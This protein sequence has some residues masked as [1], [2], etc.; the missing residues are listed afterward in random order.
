MLLIIKAFEMHF[1]EMF[2]ALNVIRIF[3]GAGLIG[4]MIS[5]YFFPDILYGLPRVPESMM[6][7]K[8][9]KSSE[10]SLTGKENTNHNHFETS[11]LNSIGH[12]TDACMKE[13]KPYLQTDCNLASISKLMNIPVHHLTYY[14][15]QVKKQHFTEY[16]NEWRINHAKNLIIEGKIKLTTLENIGLQSGFTNRNTFLTAFKRLEGTSPHAYT[17]LYKQQFATD[18]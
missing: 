5:P 3:S 17:A 15:S 2:F 10:T 1:S 4:L 11:Y 9:E 12:M 7:E 18:N 14:F 16:R 6:E 13:Y 8:P